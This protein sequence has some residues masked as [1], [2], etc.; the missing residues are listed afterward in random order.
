M[1]NYRNRMYAIA[2]TVLALVP[3]VLAQGFTAPAAPSTPTHLPQIYQR[4]LDEDVR[5]IIS[6]EERTQFLVLQSDDDRDG[7]V[8]GF[9]ER[10]NPVPGSSE[11]TFKEEHYRRIAYANEHFASTLPGWQTDRGHVYVV[12]GPPEA[13]TYARDANVNV[14][15]WHYDAGRA[16]AHPHVVRFV[17]R[18]NCGEYRVEP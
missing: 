10:R 16:D 8:R 5:Y 15:T 14:E 1:N 9:W 7:F 11:N 3:T 18:C 13:I 6:A 12:E 17:D 4:W 2:V